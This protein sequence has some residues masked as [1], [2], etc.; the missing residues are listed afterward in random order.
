MAKTKTSKKK[1]AKKAA[2]KKKKTSATD[3]PLPP[4]QREKVLRQFRKL[5]IP[6]S[7]PSNVTGPALPLGYEEPLP[8]KSKARKS[9]SRRA[10]KK[11]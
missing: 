8:K 6:P 9:A 11:R 3:G 5:A 10:K 7:H 2:T 4:K 1:P